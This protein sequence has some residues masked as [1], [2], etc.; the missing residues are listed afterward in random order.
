MFQ[1][2]LAFILRA[3]NGS[4]IAIKT[5]ILRLRF[6]SRRITERGCAHTAVNNCK[7]QWLQNFRDII[8]ATW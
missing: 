2:N 1:R 3:V 7:K 8:D 5:W 4:K 6:A